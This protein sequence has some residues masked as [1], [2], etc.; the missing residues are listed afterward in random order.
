[1]H[2]SAN[3]NSKKTTGDTFAEGVS[4]IERFFISEEYWRGH[5]EE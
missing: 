2:V 4:E 1:M 3:N 5:R